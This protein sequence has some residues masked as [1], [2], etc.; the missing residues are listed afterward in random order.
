MQTSQGRMLDSLKAVQSFLDEHATALGDVA[1]GPAR[2]RLD[3]IVAEL[4]AHV[5]EQS[6]SDLAAQGN[7][8]KQR[9]LR[10]ALYRDHIAPISRIARADLPDTPEVQPLKMPRGKPSTQKLASIARGMAKAAAPYAP[11]FVSGGLPAD[12]IARLDAATNALLQVAVER[13]RNRGRRGGATTGLKDRLSAGRKIVR[14]LDA[15]VKSAGANDPVLVA[16]WN[17]VKRVQLLAG[18]RTASPSS[19]VP[20]SV[21]AASAAP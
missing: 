2:K 10:I 4:A 6:G 3:D 8:K 12:F 21:P 7:T 1:T 9:A 18:P 5:A 16:D 17:S 20:V 19:G 15:L 13:S 11:V 14:V